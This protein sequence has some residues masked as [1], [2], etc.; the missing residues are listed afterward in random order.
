[1][2][3]QTLNLGAQI[4]LSHA[5]CL[6]LPDFA[7]SLAHF[8][9]NNPLS[10]FEVQHRTIE[11]YPAIRAS[12]I[13]PCL[14]LLDL[15]LPPIAHHGQAH[16]YNRHTHQATQRSTGA[17]TSL[18]LPGSFDRLSN[19]MLTCVPFQGHVV[20]LEITSGQVYRGKLL[21]GTLPPIPISHSTV[22]VPC[23]SAS[24]LSGPD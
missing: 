7:C 18:S 24:L 14:S 12:T 19:H 8:D 17:Q 15:G 11:L 2:Q 16:L 23:P 20:T 22:P 5:L 9:K 10:H 13:P 1:M 4:C 21:E 3:V 6:A